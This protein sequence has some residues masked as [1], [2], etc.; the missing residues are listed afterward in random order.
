MREMPRKKKEDVENT[1]E[2]VEANGSVETKKEA[3]SAK[4]QGTKGSVVGKTDAD[5][6]GKRK[7]GRPKKVETVEAELVKKGGVGVNG[8][9]IPF[10]QRTESERREISVKAG[11][12][13]GISRRHKK[14]LRE[15]TQD[16]LLHDAAPVIQQNMKVFGVD[17]DDMSNLA[18]IVVRLFNKAV[19]NG[20]LNSARTLIEWAGMAP[21]QQEREN[22][23]IAKMSQAMQLAG[24]GT[25]D[26]DDD[27]NIV[28]YIPSNGRDACIDAL[29]GEE[30]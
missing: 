17:P 24:G 28:F 18:A 10:N 12:A 14:E 26:S 11:I 16:F 15:F 1:I 3:T 4:K 5:V 8:N 22:E 29:V 20:D 27:T 25:D 7:P 23:A 21:L 2:K 9:L 19:N 30:V 6:K 13:S